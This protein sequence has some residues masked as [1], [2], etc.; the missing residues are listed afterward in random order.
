MSTESKCQDL[1]QEFPLGISKKFKR[2]FNLG[3]VQGKWQ[4]VRDFFGNV[5]ESVF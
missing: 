2:E 1:G 5:T 3:H 4:L